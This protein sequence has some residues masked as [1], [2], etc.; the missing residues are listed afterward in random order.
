[1]DMLQALRIGSLAEKVALENFLCADRAYHAY[2]IG[3]L[4]EPYFSQSEWWAAQD[5]AAVRALVLLFHGLS[6]AVLFSMGNEAGVIAEIAHHIPL[7]AT[8]MVLGQS[9]HMMVWQSFY[10]FGRVDAMW[11]MVLLPENF[12]PPSDAVPVQRLDDRHL[13]QLLACYR[14]EYGNAFA[15][16]QLAQ[17]VFYGIFDDTDLVSVAGTHIVAPEYRLAAIGNVLTAPAYRN[18]GYGKR[19]TAAVCAHLL[20]QG[21]DTL[22]LNV[23]QSNKSAIRV[24]E[25]LGFA[26]HRTFEE[27]IGTLKNR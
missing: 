23:R 1:M 5:D 18:R 11:R 17:G 10:H 7:P 2:A 20:A 14:H 8:A 19:V 22:V 3:D 16:T 4:V 21:C 12:A 24:Y 25:S 27:G 15:P 26:I 13:P 6:P 9:E